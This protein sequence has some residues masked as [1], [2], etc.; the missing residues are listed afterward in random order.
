MKVMWSTSGDAI[1]VNLN[2]VSFSSL[3]RILRKLPGLKF[4]KSIQNPMNDDASAIFV[5]KDIQFEI[6][7]PISDCWIDR[8]ENCSKEIFNEITKFLETS[9]VRWWQRIF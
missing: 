8:P 2:E 3:I 6:N 9:Q 5:Y 1:G 7:T 4:K